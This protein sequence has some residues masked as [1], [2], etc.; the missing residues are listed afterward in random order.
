MKLF[1]RMANCS[2]IAIVDDDKIFH[3]LT[4]RIIEKADV[5]DRILEFYDGQ[6]A[7]SYIF[8]NQHNPGQLPDLVFLDIQMPFMDGWQFL[9]QYVTL[10]IAKTIT[11]YVVSSSI[12]SLD[13]E[14]SHHFPVIKDFII[15]PFT[16]DKVLEILN[17]FK[18]Y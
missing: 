17:E 11:I 18:G 7:F 14:K 3:A 1:F 15:K 4:R 8:E 16:R 5:S 2:T 9:E 10:K 6:E 12:S 13:H